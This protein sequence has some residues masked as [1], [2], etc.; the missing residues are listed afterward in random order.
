MYKRFC[1]FVFFFSFILLAINSYAEN[2]AVEIKTSLGNFTVELYPEKAPKTVENFL[3]YVDEG[4]YKNTIFHR[5]I[6]NFMVQG[7]GFNADLAQK[8]TRSPIPIES[9]NGLK[10]DV[11]TIAMARTSDPN[12]ATAQF[13]IN[14]VNND[15]LNFKAPNA[16]GYGYAV[17][18]KVTQG[19]DIVNKIA[20]TPTG[21]AGPLS[22][23]VPKTTIL[24]QDI[25]RVTQA[26]KTN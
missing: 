23:D 1:Q 15:F 6:P 10:N 5:V 24:I 4:F 12:S 3:Q 13:F 21:S 25:V 8:P 22:R 18:G 14:V 9:N 20:A 19:M 2:I 17:F 16:S 26:A 7:G 11:G